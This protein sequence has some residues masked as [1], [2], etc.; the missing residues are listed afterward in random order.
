MI[1]YVAIVVVLV[2]LALA[3]SGYACSSS[4]SAQ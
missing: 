4:T 3:A 2:V 1:A